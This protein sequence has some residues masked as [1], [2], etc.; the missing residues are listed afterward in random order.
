M[1]LDVALEEANHLHELATRP[2]K[3]DMFK[4]MSNKA[5]YTPMVESI[6]LYLDQL[7]QAKRQLDE[8]WKG[9]SGKQQT[10]DV[11]EVR[12]SISRVSNSRAHL[13]DIKRSD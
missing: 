8:V 1:S 2:G 13:Q 5:L 6:K 11:M 9:E 12:E 7:L 4:A 3:N 10:I